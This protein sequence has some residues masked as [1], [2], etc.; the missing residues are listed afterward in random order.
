[1]LSPIPRR[2]FVIWLGGPLPPIRATSLDTIRRHSGVETVLVTEDSL[3]RWVTT[4]APLHQAFHQLSAIHQADYLRCYLMHHH[5]GGYLDVERLSQ[6]RILHAAWWRYRWLQLN[7]RRLIGT[8]AFVCRPRS[9][10]ADAW[11]AGMTRRLDGFQAALAANPARHP[12]DHAGFPIDGR[13]SSYPVTWTA[14][15]AD[16]FH[17]LALHHRHQIL[18]TLPPPAFTGYQ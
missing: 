2:V 13:P 11:F 4:A 1:M 18:T 12:R 17:P 10:F 8:C 7:Y 6:P 14:L 3:D 5:G 15:L 16:I 9:A